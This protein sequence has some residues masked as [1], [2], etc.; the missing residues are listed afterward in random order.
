LDWSKY[1]KAGP[2]YK[3]ALAIYQMVFGENHPNYAQ[4][5]NST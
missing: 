5:L 1:E 4:T 2:I 3:R